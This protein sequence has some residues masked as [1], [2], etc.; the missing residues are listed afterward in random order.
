M[1]LELLTFLNKIFHD[2][3]IHDVV[4]AVLV[5][6]VHHQCTLVYTCT[7]KLFTIP[8]VHKYT[9]QCRMNSTAY[10]LILNLFDTDSLKL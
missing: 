7:G 2:Q 10:S 9:V 3:Q 6:Y 8:Y 1:T 4:V 5:Q